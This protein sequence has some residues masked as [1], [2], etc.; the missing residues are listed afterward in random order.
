MP[1]T[2]L[3]AGIPVADYPA[4]LRWYERL[5]GQAPSFFPHETEAVWQ[6]TDH[7]WVYVVL[8]AGRAGNALL[9][10]LVD[11]LETRVRQLSERGLPI[12]P[13][14]EMPQGVHVA[15]I[16]DPEGNRIQFGQPVAAGS[17]GA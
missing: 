15:W 16:T 14:E 17:E 11:D 1:N 9:T 13:I 6:V 2:E 8:D 12:G 5:F 10:V 3:F 7:G 4:M